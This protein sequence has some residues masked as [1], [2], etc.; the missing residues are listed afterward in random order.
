M[1][2]NQLKVQEKKV[3]SANDE[4]MKSESCFAPPVDI[5]ET[6]HEVI[7]LADM[8]GIG[9]E[10]IDLSLENNILTL[11]GHRDLTPLSTGRVLLEEYESGHYL[12]RFT[13]DKSINQEGIEATLTDGVL[14]VH[15]PKSI[16]AQPR[17]IEVKI[18]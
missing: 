5:Y 7:I 1:G 15:L 14:K 2:D 6:E 16:P 18:S 10:G 3:A 9:I 11:I 17:R 4:S 13:V 8:P 12:R